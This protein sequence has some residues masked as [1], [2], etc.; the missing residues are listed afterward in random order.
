LL[1]AGGKNQNARTG[2]TAVKFVIAIF[3]LLL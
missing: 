2:Q 3:K 1:V